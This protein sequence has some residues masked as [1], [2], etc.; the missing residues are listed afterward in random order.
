MKTYYSLLWAVFLLCVTTINVRAQDATDI[1]LFGERT[2]P[3][4]IS[5]LPGGDYLILGS[6]DS[7][8]YTGNT[9]LVRSGRDFMMRVD[10]S[11]NLKWVR[12]Y[13]YAL[14]HHLID[15]YGR[16]WLCSSYLF[17]GS[18]DLTGQLP[19]PGSGSG[20]FI[21]RY[22]LNGHMDF[23]RS[24]ADDFRPSDM[25][26]DNQGNI[27]IA[28][29]I[30]DSAD[31]GGG[32]V[33]FYP[34]W[35]GDA[36]FVKLDTAGDYLWAK[37]AGA[38]P[39]LLCCFEGDYFQ[40]IVVDNA[41][42]IYVNGN[43]TDGSWFDTIQIQDTVNGTQG[44]LA[45]YN[46]AG[47][48]QWV[49]DCGDTPK[50][51]EV[52]DDGN[53]YAIIS[54]RGRL[55]GDQTVPA[56]VQGYNLI[57]AKFNSSGHTLWQ[58]HDMSSNNYNSG[59]AKMLLGEDG[60]LYVSGSFRDTLKIDGQEFLQDCSNVN[61]GL[62]MA[63]D[64]GG[65]VHWAKTTC[66]PRT[67]YGEFSA[68]GCNIAI[69]GSYSDYANADSLTLHIDTFS[70]PSVLDNEVFLV[71]VAINNCGFI[72]YDTIWPGDVNADG[73]VTNV[74]LLYLGVAFGNSGYSRAGASINWTGQECQSWSSN[75]NSIP[76]NLDNADCNGDGVVDLA[77]TLAIG[78][79]YGLT[80]QK[81]GSQQ[82]TGGAPLMKLTLAN[83]PVM[84]GETA[85]FNVTLG[86]VV[87]PATDFHGVSFTI[88][89]N[90]D[91]L[92]T[93]T[94]N[95][96]AKNSWLGQPNVN[97][98]SLQTKPASGNSI[99]VASTRIDR[100]NQ[101]GQGVIG[102]L[103]AKLLDYGINKDSTIT[104]SQELVFDIVDAQGIDV[105]ENLL[106]INTAS[107]T[108]AVSKDTIIS[109]IDDT[110]GIIDLNQTY[111]SLYP[112]PAN[113]RVNLQLTPEALANGPVHFDLYSLLGEHLLTRQI[114]T[115]NNSIELDQKKGVYFYSVTVN[116][117]SH[118]GR[119]VLLE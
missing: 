21:A 33:P 54:G 86:D 79:N 85:I 2:E 24:L 48:I 70:V 83:G 58:L 60:M 6:F 87:T 39:D 17:A 51:I 26:S 73:V 71:N 114:T 14:D 72:S 11:Y 118:S 37:T 74:D 7:L 82:R 36:C 59:L 116:G 13:N 75:F 25:T 97:L 81:G 115:V 109:V 40:S 112:N 1:R 88:V 113:G 102:Q 3:T 84:P 67:G 80:H 30:V 27:Y 35:H 62:I 41:G 34:G 4:S 95:Y 43:F 16:I 22:D 101:T 9:N 90:P 46:A 69:L 29:S 89:F 106:P 110:T 15:P 103:K 111:F 76:V 38:P 23:V 32:P 64:T 65:H 10:S 94:V 107:D 98:I 53:V 8:I 49:E 104:L 117:I 105:S 47:Q 63:L 96:T 31:F 18:F 108:F 28:G 50:D 66:G 92:D 19:I 45:K 55:I 99:E 91:L 77:D 78:Q 42:N 93:A 52:D 5:I 68:D 20:S 57:V 56:G 119:L 44:I 12:T 100:V 61:G